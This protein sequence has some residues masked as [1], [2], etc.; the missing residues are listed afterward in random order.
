M[1]CPLM[2]HKT[3]QYILRTWDKK[4]IKYVKAHFTNQKTLYVVTGIDL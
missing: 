4:Q 3:L 1:L 2:S